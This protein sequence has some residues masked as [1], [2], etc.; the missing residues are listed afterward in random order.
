MTDKYLFG[1][2]D[3]AARRLG[4]LAGAFAPSSKVFLVR[5]A[6]G[7]IRVAADLGCGPG[8]TTHLMADTVKCGHV[9]GLDNSQHFIDL[10][11]QT[12]RERVSFSLHDVTKVPFPGVRFDLIYGRFLLTH[13]SDSAGLIAKW[14]S[15]LRLSGRLLIEDV[16]G[17]ETDIPAFVEYLRIVEAMLADRGSDLFVGRSLDATPA[18]QSAALVSSETARAA[19]RT[20]IAAQMF[21][22]NI[23]TWKHNA[24]VQANC[25][26]ADIEKLQDTLTDLAAAPTRQAGIEWS[27]RQLAYERET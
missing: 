18:P 17:I 1:D 2:T 15:Q 11:R 25:A 5:A 27:L 24:Y 12:A 14:A 21:A 22:M 8:H 26:P 4:V 20:D 10:A 6:G 19:V 23:R 9:V 3:L 7:E 13:Q 16:D